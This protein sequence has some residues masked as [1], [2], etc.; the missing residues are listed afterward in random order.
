MNK[1]SLLAGWQKT[2]HGPQQKQGCGGGREKFGE[3]RRDKRDPQRGSTVQY[4]PEAEQVPDMLADM[5]L[6]SCGIGCVERCHSAYV[7]MAKREH[8]RPAT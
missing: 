4:Q 6:F 2:E 5:Y 7:R 3:Q 1:E 8:V